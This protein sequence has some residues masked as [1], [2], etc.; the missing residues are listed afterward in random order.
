MIRS[1]AF[2]LSVLALGFAL[3][4]C[5]SGPVRRINP[6][7]ASLQQLAVTPDGAWEI[8][9]RVQNFSTVPMTFASLEAALEVEGVNAGEV[10][11]HL[12]IEIPGGKADVVHTRLTPSA[13]ARSGFSAAAKDGSIGYKLNGSIEASEPKKH[14]EAHHESRLSAVP[15]LPDTYR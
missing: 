15:G 11:V 7:V 13:A 1:F 5:G 4:S 2:R 12:D 9:V 14:F 8:D 3:A 10:F 6:P